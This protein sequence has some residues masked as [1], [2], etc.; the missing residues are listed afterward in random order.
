MRITEKDLQAT[1]DCINRMLDTPL[2]PYTQ[3][4]GKL[5]ANV[6]CYHLDHDYGDVALHQMDNA[7]GGVRDI[8]GGH[9]TKRELYERMHAFIKGIEEVKK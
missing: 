8:L 2:E 9:L 6:G 4:E 1:C 5:V 7:R 3:A